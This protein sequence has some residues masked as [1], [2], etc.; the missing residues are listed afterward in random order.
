MD[1][2]FVAVGVS[3]QRDPDGSKLR[4]FL[5]S[6]IALERAQALRDFLIHL[7]AAASLPLGFLV[8]RPV[9]S[10]TG[11]RSVTLAGWLTCTIAL[12]LT[13]AR[14][15]RHRRRCAALMRDLGPPP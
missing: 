5:Q 3:P 7:L 10:V 4:T 8:V 2:D 13:A 9:G 12:G 1:S 11:F 15:W 14:E 6:Q